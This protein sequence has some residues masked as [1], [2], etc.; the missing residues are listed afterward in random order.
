MSRVIITKTE[1]Y[2]SCYYCGYI[3]NRK[4]RLEGEPNIKVCCPNCFVDKINHRE[5]GDDS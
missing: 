5:V 4:C 1:A 3:T 2:I